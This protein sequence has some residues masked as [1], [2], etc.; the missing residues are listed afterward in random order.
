LKLHSVVYIQAANQKLPEF[1]WSKETS[2]NGIPHLKVKFFDGG[3]DDVV[4][5]DPWNPLPAET[6]PDSVKSRPDPVKS[7]SDP[8]SCVFK[9]HLKSEP[10]SSV[11]VTGG[12]P[13]EDSFEVKSTFLHSK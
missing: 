5:L 8:D 1:I 6:R 2:R 10:G 13:G 4:V 11:I 3:Q 12:C 7:R 9:G